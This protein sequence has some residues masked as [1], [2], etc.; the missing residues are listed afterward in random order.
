MLQNLPLDIKAEAILAYMPKEK[1]RVEIRGAHKRNAYED[2]GEITDNGDGACA[3]SICRNGL[4]DILP[5][6]LFHPI[7]RFDNIPANEYKERFKEECELQQLE[8]ENARRFFEPFDV[9]LAELSS[10]VHNLKNSDGI[11]SALEDIICDAFPPKYRENRF[12]NKAKKFMPQCKNIR[13][14]KTLMALMLRQIMFDEGMSIEE[15]TVTALFSD[16]S[17]RYN[18]RLDDARGK[19]EETY[20]GNE[21]EEDLTVYD[22][23]YW[24]DEHCDDS[25]LAFVAEI[26]TFEE[27]LNDYFVGIEARLR[28]EISASA[29]PVRLSDEIFFNYLDYNTNI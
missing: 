16:A 29:L 4:Y 19:N 15:R 22:I 20:L 1:R 24:N 26:E 17:P 13:G 21:Y 7:D 8:E 9:F 3:I 10:L 12:V 28:F 2:I 27:F 6:C 5:E 11:N 18:F 14:N 25:F 23:K